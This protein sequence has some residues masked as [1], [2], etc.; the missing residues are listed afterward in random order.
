MLS[1]LVLEFTASCFDSRTRTLGGGDTFQ[2][3]RTTNFAGQHDFDALY[4]LVDQVGILQ[5]LQAD[6]VAFDLGQLGGAYFSTIHS[7]RE[8][9]PNFGRRR[10]RGC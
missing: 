8:T 9:K 1:H 6:D 2:G 7:L 5:G 3:D 10:C 4:V